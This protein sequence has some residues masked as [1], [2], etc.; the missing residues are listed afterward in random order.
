[1][2]RELI[3]IVAVTILAGCRP[4]TSQKEYGTMQVGDRLFAGIGVVGGTDTNAQT[5]ITAALKEHGIDSL[6]EGSAVYGIWVPKEQAEEAE[7]IIRRDSK[8]KEYWIEI[9]R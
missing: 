9:K 6:M 5:L 2:M 7:N 3:V 8:D 1:M 4:E